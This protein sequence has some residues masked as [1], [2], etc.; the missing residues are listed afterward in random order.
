MK[1]AFSLLHYNNL[2]VTN[3]AVDCLQKLPGIENAEI[4]IVD[5][6]SPNH[7]G[8]EL[9][10]LY[11]DRAH[12]HVVLNSK[13]G[14]FAY[15]NNEGYRY[16]R[17]YL[18]CDTIAVMNNDVFIRDPQFME[19][20]ERLDGETDA[21]IIAP[22]ILGRNGA[23]NPFRLKELSDQKLR[24]MYNYNSLIHTVYGI[25]GIANLLAGYLDRKQKDRVKQRPAIGDGTEC[26]PHGACLIYRRPWVEKE[27]IAFLPD[28][29]MYF[30]EDILAEYMHHRGYKARFYGDLKVHH[31][32]DASVE[33]DNKTSVKKRRFISGCMKD[34]IGILMNMREKD[35]LHR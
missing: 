1:A 23:Q 32:E 15:G 3:E 33:Y 35:S 31:M 30:E 25:P 13:N 10:K 20:L 19:K 14:G 5:N 21:E 24:K 16:A 9:E 8:E 34:S 29:F 17:D 4:I 22:D 6:C 26:I 28:T 11:R 12:I 27:E 2:Q 18:G 7:T